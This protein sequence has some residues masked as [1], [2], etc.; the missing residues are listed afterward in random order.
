V[1]Y[2]IVLADTELGR[3]LQTEYRYTKPAKSERA[4]AEGF[5]RELAFLKIR[6]KQPENGQA[7]QLEFPIERERL[8]TELKNASADFRFAAAVSAFGQVLRQ[9]RYLTPSYRLGEIAKLAEDALGAD[10]SGYRREFVELVKDAEAAS[11]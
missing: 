7:A 8:R 11:R 5:G 3:Q 6:F 9:S 4:L 10:P 1:L 2:E